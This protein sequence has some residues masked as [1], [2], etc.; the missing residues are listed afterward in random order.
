MSRDTFLLITSSTLLIIAII[1]WQELF[2]FVKTTVN[3]PLWAKG[4]PYPMMGAHLIALIA[5]IPVV[6]LS[7][8]GITIIKNT[9]ITLLAS[10]SIAITALII[11]NDATLTINRFT[12][13]F[14]WVTLINCL[15]PAILLL[16]IRVIADVFIGKKANKASQP[17]PKSGAAEL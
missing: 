7:K 12:N 1:T 16:L 11:S 8:P 4:L 13:E 5:L 10:A 15:P 2:V 17:T 9:T 14:I 3:Y 6:L